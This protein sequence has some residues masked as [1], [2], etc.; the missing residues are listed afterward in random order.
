[1]YNLQPVLP[2]LFPEP[3]PVQRIDPIRV[4]EDTMRDRWLQIRALVA[5]EVGEQQANALQRTLVDTLYRK[6]ELFEQEAAIYWSSAYMK[7]HGC[8][9]KHWCNASMCGEYTSCPMAEILRGE[10]RRL[11]EGR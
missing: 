8:Y 11:M 1:M 10:G 2:G 6:V 4:H 9:G 7:H 5:H 3:A